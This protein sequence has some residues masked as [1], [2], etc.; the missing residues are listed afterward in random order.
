MVDKRVSVG[1]WDCLER[2]REMPSRAELLHLSGLVQE[3]VARLAA[4][5]PHLPV[6]VRRRITETVSEMAEADFM[7]D[8]SAMLRVALGDEDAQVRTAAIYGLWED[9]D[10][11]LIPWL[12]RLLKEDEAV[13]TRVAA[14]QALGRFI[15]LGELRKIR[16]VA[17]RRAREALLESHT[18]ADED[19]EVRRRA[20]ESLAYTGDYGVPE[21][22]EAG[23]AHPAEKMRISAV[24]AMGRS[25]DPRWG[26]IVRKE[27]TNL[28]PEMRYEAAR[29]CG[30]LGL[31]EAVQELV[32]MA[33]DVD[34]EV[35]EAALWSLG[36]IGGRLA[37]RVLE[38]YARSDNEALQAVAQEALEAWDLIHGDLESFFGPPIEYLGREEEVAWPEDEAWLL[39]EE[40]W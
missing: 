12:A 17:F 4:I 39:D 16:P 23:Y 10:V 15:L 21:L 7:L 31:Q 3:E 1:L 11:R 2:R 18:N 14:A 19:L 25:A 33:E 6:E 34:P 8:F 24:F 29:A 37:R 13:Q 27:L 9:N 22:I 35:Q 28:N 36:Q 20:L 5:W 40:V 32:E 26:K 30:E 38:H